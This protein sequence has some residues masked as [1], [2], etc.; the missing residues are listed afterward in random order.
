MHAVSMQ[1]MYECVSAERTAEN[2][3]IEQSKNK[4][5]LVLLEPDASVR[6]ALSI[7]LGSEHWQV[8]TANDCVGMERALADNRVSVVISE[9][10]LPG[11]TP[12][13][14]LQ[15]C[16]E[17]KLPVIFTGHELSL[18]G[19]VDLIREGALDY[20]EKPFPQDR[21]VHLLERIHNRQH[22]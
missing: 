6:D 11:C 13:Q 2:L 15:K 20:L 9:S 16:Q 18:Q 21:L 22:N 4:G 19:A 12:G 8:L 1:R 3:E 10:S 17:R 7:L 14:I 5:T